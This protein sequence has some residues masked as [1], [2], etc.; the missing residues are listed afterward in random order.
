MPFD[1]QSNTAASVQGRV[2][3]TD[4]IEG[5]GAMYAAGWVKRGPTGIIGTNITD[6]K[7][8]VS[9]IVADVESGRLALKEHDEADLSSLLKERHCNFID[10]D[11]YKRIEAFETRKG[12]SSQ[13]AKPREKLV[14]RDEMLSIAKQ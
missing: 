1:E 7:E 6:A 14:D 10:W 9:S 2:N 4:P 11:E 3:D 8:T 12:E 5:L 13:P